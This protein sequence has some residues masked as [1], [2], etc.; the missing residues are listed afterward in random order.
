MAKFRLLPAIYLYQ[1]KMVNIDTKEV[2]ADGDAVAQA[3]ALGNLGADELLIFDLSNDDEG[4]EKNI[5]TMI[6][7][8]DEADIPTIVGGNVNR[9][10]DVKKY[11]YSGAKKAFLDTSKES[12]LDLLKEASERF[13]NDKIAVL[14]HEDF[15]FSKIKQLKYDGASLLIADN[16]ARQCFGQ[17]IRVVSY[18]A[19]IT[20]AQFVEMG[21]GE[22]VYGISEGCMDET[23]PYQNTVLHS[24]LRLAKKHR[25]ILTA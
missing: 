10:E 12:N 20:P 6:K 5:S 11:L 22:K 2:I 23:Y 1:G 24:Y 8:S 25:H 3:I 14:V 17:E 13:G 16:C 4:H 19:G 9:L 7:I 21:I 18:N 15:D